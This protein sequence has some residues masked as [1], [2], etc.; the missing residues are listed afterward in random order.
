LT[1][2]L[3]L[4]SFTMCLLAALLVHHRPFGGISIRHILRGTT[5]ALSVMLLAGL[6]LTPTQATTITEYSVPG[7]PGLWDLSIN[8]ASSI[9]WFTESGANNVG[10]LNYGDSTVRQIP[11]PTLNSQPWGI[12][13]PSGWLGTGAIFTESYGNR[14]GIVSSASNGTRYVAEYVIPTSGSGP[15]K[16]IFDSVRNCTWFT[17]YAAGQIGRFDI[18]TPPGWTGRFIE[19]KLPGGLSLP[20]QSNPIGLALDPIGPSST[21][22]YIWIADFGRKSIIRFLP[23]TGE[24]RE[25]S[26]Y[27]F[28]PWD[29][30]LDADGFVWFTAQ[31]VGTD[32]NIIGRIDSARQEKESA[33]QS[34]W[35]FNIFRV[36]TPNSE[37]HELEIDS[38]G[39]VWF[40]EFSDQASKIGKYVPMHNVFSEYLVLMPIS[41][42]QGL[43]LYE[44][45]G[46]VN[47]W[48]AEYG[49]RRIGRLRQ[50]EGPT[51]STTVWSISSAVS[52][53]STILTVSTSPTTA[54][55]VNIPNAAFSTP[56][57]TTTTASTASSTLVDTIS[58]IKTSPT[59]GIYT[60]TFTTSTSYSTTTSTYQLTY[61]TVLTTSTTTSVTATSVSTTWEGLTILSTA[62]Y[63]SISYITQTTSTTATITQISTI[64][65]PTVTIPA[66]VRTGGNI[67]AYSPTV[68]MTSTTS[69]GSTTTTTST[70]LTTTTTYSPTVTLTSTTTTVTT[71]F[72]LG[73]GLRPCIIASAAYGSE[74]AE[75]VQTLR[76]FRDY[77]V[78][79]TFAGGEFMKAFNSFYYSFSPAVASVVASSQLV[80]AP[81]RLAI[82]PLVGVL[83]V[84]SAVSRA[85][86]FA[87]EIGVIVAGLFSSA[88]IGFVYGTPFVAVLR[89]LRKRK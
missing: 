32:E 31:R 55:A 39:N 3:L 26:V 80:A 51:V 53:S 27:P 61:V 76:E 43:A 68:T 49:G 30:A 77:E 86:A 37:V 52:T 34:R 38:R 74:L 33:L 63:Q 7:N 44:S 24:M 10:Y 46:V 6:I 60:Y 87:P 85:F 40:T 64:Y 11:V 75:P 84:S 36:P 28:S 2:V 50:P 59:Y 8:G 73:I 19:Y 35:A 81:V 58:L 65:S 72:P 16:I 47:V 71:A 22:R 82:Y 15:R 54:S 89:F 56:V 83:Q 67:T 66:T 62:T 5:A 41:K 29:V 57:V 69:V 20:I 70:L 4:M 45:G 42:P 21:Q 14:I 17:E 48:F 9:V 88:A 18:P 23:E 1:P 79:S 25:Y 78:R 13:I 12:T